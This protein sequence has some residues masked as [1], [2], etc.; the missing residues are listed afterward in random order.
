MYRLIILLLAV[1][2]ISCRAK[3]ETYSNTSKSTSVDSS[4]SMFKYRLSTLDSNYLNYEF[5]KW[6]FKPGT[7]G[8]DTVGK[9]P[10]AIAPELVSVTQ[11]KVSS[12]SGSKT[13][14][15]AQGEDLKLNKTAESKTESGTK[16]VKP[17][18]NPFKVGLY[19]FI[20][21]F[22]LAL[23][24]SW[25]QSWFSH[26][27]VPEDPG[28]TLTYEPKEGEVTPLYNRKGTFIGWFDTSKAL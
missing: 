4:A 1:S 12:G 8:K 18:A 27:L 10:S 2:L 20:V 17:G 7:T 15:D 14:I 3:K 16:D 24:L 25:R 13:N 19:A 21:G 9:I 23:Y 22:V 28:P 6:E 5:T 26:K 11:G